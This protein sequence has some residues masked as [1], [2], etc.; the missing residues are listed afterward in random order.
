MVLEKLERLWPGLASLKLA[1]ISLA[2]LAGVL[3]YATFFNS[4]HGLTAAQEVR[5][6]RHRREPQD[7]ERGGDLV[8]RVRCPGGP[9]AQHRLGVR[10]G[11]EEDEELQVEARKL[12][13]AGALVEHAQRKQIFAHE[14]FCQTTAAHPKSESADTGC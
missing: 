11:D 1:V 9:R 7:P 2:T 12:S 3:C 10:D 6:L 8:R 14:N 13:Q 4:W 5:Q